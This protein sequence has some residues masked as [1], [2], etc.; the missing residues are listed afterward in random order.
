MKIEIK[1]ADRVTD[2][3]KQLFWEGVRTFEKDWLLSIQKEA[4]RLYGLWSILYY[5]PH[6][7]IKAVSYCSG[8]LIISNLALIVQN[9]IE[10]IMHGA[11][12]FYVG[13]LFLI[14]EFVAL[15]L[16]LNFTR[17]DDEQYKHY[18]LEQLKPMRKVLTNK[19]KSYATQLKIKV[20]I[21]WDN[22]EKEEN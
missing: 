22:N 2:S 3:T 11:K 18:C 16:F 13:I 9:Y 19:I 17:G 14:M 7:F 20:Y 10:F 21:T 4:A 6:G 12:F 5:Q 8:A 15:L 1:N